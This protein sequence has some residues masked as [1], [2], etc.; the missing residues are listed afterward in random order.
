MKKLLFYLAL[1]TVTVFAIATMPAIADIV[2]PNRPI[3]LGP[4]WDGPD[5]DLQDFFDGTIGYGFPK[6]PSGINATSDQQKT[7]IFVSGS[8]L[9]ADSTIMLEVS[10]YSGANQIGIYEYGNPTNRLLAIGGLQS[11]GYNVTI[12]FD[13]NNDGVG[14]DI[15]IYDGTP[16]VISTGTFNSLSFGFYIYTGGQNYFYTED[17]LNPEGNPQALTFLGKGAW[18][19]L[20]DFYIAFE[21]L[22]FDANYGDGGWSADNDFNDIV[23]HASDVDAAVP[24]PATMFLLGS[25]LIGLAGFARRRFLKK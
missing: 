18:G 24:E 5:Y 19:D 23:I 10:G 4:S 3:V 25:G 12:D 2:N 6:P 17:V 14:G 8:D 9:L 1:A 13:A 20:G 15:K 22:V 11:T 21:D 7:A 16:A